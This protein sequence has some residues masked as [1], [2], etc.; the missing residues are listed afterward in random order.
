MGFRDLHCFNLAMLAKQAWWL[1]AEP[2]SLCSRVLR[3]QY[4]PDG[5]LLKARLK[6]GSSY[7]WQSVLAG[8]E[9]FKRGYIWR[10]GD[11]SQINIWEYNWIPTS[12]N[13]KV[14]TP[15]GRNIVT[16]VNELINPVTRQWDVELISYLFWSIDVHRILQI[17]IMSGREDLVAWHYDRNGLFSVKSAHHC[18]WKHKFGSHHYGSVAGGISNTQV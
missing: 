8:L 3:S 6:S 5:N 2:N 1:M 18:Q 13:L 17:P 12:Q 14:Q 10:V 16:I 4:Y 7:T 9:C 15:R 11:G